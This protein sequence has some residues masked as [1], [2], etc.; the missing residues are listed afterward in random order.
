MATSIMEEEDDDD[1]AVNNDDFVLDDEVD[2]DAVF[3]D[4]L[5]IP[6]PNRLP[7]EKL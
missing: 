5:S 2:R 7:T 3:S 6:P 1:R 4:E